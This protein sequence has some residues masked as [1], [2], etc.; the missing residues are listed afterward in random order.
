MKNWENEGG[1]LD[2]FKYTDYNEGGGIRTHILTMM[3]QSNEIYQSK[4]SGYGAG[5][6]HRRVIETAEV[7]NNFLSEYDK[8]PKKPQHRFTFP[9]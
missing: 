6:C 3:Q 1:I 9:T 8:N 7:S 2:L 4:S 5:F